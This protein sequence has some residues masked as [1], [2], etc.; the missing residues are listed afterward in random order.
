MKTKSQEETEVILS[1][2]KRIKELEQ[3][4]EELK[5]RIFTLTTDKEYDV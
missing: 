2:G 5:G 1:M 3:E 4:V